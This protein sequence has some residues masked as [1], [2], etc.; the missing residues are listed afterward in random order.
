MDAAHGETGILTERKIFDMQNAYEA[1][2]ISSKADDLIEK[3]S[4]RGLVNITWGIKRWNDYIAREKDQKRKRKAILEQGNAELERYCAGK[5]IETTAFMEKF[6]KVT[7]AYGLVDIINDIDDPIL[8]ARLIIRVTEISDFHE[9]R[10]LRFAYS[11][12]KD[13]QKLIAI[14]K[15]IDLSVPVSKTG[16]ESK[17]DRASD[18]VIV[19]IK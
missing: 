17:Y 9:K 5:N 13:L 15:D 19:S 16:I 18:L 2:V 6:R 8:R 3:L 7:P 4:E 10:R 14:L 1:A 12:E 11:P